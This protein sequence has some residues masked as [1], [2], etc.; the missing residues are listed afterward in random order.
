MILVSLS[1]NASAQTVQIPSWIK[2]N[3]KYWSEGQ[4]QDS[5]FTKGIQYLMDKGIMKIPQTKPSST[6]SNTIPSWVKNNAKYWSEG[7][8]DDSEF[9]K[10]IQYLVESGI[11]VVNT[12]QCDP[13]LWEHV[14]HPQRL[15]IIQL[16]TQ[17][18]GIIEHISTEKDGDYHIRLALDPE[19]DSMINQANAEQQHGDMVLEPI[20][21][22]PVEQQDAISS[23]QGFSDIINIPPVGTHVRVTGSYVL[24]LEHSS[25]AEIH[26]VTAIEEIFQNGMVSTTIQ[27]PI[28]KPNS[29]S[30]QTLRIDLAEHD[31]ITRGTIQEMIVE[32]S[33]GTNPVSGASVSVHV[34]Y[35]SGSTTKD[36]S[37]TTDS[38][39]EFSLSWKIGSNSTP[40]TFL[41]DIDASKDGYSSA[42]ETFSF[43]VVPAS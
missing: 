2:N 13:T 20:C 34:T 33:D 25:W 26:P 7:Q 4:I 23:C 27:N 19:Y 22:N 32:V 40:G 1:S 38:N 11:I 41:V 30:N 36:F 5:D 15:N 39:G 17:V 8:I 12:V 10:G 16:C 42:H 37:G 14:Y 9:V 43:E 29:T 35:A 3:A 6:Q 18:T 21:Q 28:N 31:Y 24:D